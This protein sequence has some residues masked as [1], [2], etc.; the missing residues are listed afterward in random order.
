[1]DAIRQLSEAGIPTTIMTAPIIP[2]LNDHEIEMLLTAGRDAGATSASYVLLRLPLELKQLFH[3][4][5]QE[6]FPDR[7][8]RIMRLLQD[9][10]GGKVYRSEFGLRQ[11]GSGPLAEMIGQRFRHALK[12]LHLSERHLKMRT[13]LFQP[14]AGARDQLQLF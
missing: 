6:N 3:E 10:H 14:P 1:L 12:R 8:G 9:M 4:W 13:D 7:A 11:R 2:G 5:L